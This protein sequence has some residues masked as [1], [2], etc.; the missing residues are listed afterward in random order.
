V[1]C[2][3]RMMW[4]WIVWSNPAFPTTSVS[5][6]QQ[7]LWARHLW[8]APPFP[9][10]FSADDVCWS[11]SLPK[12]R[13][14]YG[15]GCVKACSLCNE[16][17]M[18][19][20][21]EYSLSCQINHAMKRTTAQRTQMCVP[22]WYFWAWFCVYSSRKWKT[23]AIHWPVLAPAFALNDESGHCGCPGANDA[24]VPGAHS[25]VSLW[26]QEQTNMFIHSTVWYIEVAWGIP[27]TPLRK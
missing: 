15:D 2:F 22:F 6:F 20:T 8:Q 7:L 9:A 26:K 25:D 14:G 24:N 17:D 12:P 11:H 13:F 10:Q 21:K 23:I 18:E 3:F 5:M 1:H 27:N 16:T 19:G 4:F